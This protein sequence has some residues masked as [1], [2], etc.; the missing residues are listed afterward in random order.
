MRQSTIRRAV[1]AASVTTMAGAALVVGGAAAASADPVTGT[2]QTDANL[3]GN[4]MWYSRTVS[5]GAPIFGD[6]VTITTQLERR[7][8]TNANLVYWIEDLHPGCFDY[9]DKSATWT[10]GTTEYTHTGKPS[11]VYV[12]DASMKIDP[13]AANS[14]IPPVKLVAEY[15]VNCDAGPLLTGGL[16][17]DGTTFD[18]TSAS[19]TV[20]PTVT[21]KRMGTS[22]F[23]AQPAHPQV[24]QPV[25]FNAVTTNVPDGGQVAFTV[26]GV[27]AGT[28]T[29]TNNQASLTFTPTSAGATEVRA[30][31]VQTGTHGGSASVVRTINVSQ[32]NVEATVSVAATAGARVGHATQL[33]ATVAPAGAGGT[34]VFSDHGT[35]IGSAPVGADGT[36][37]IE[38][39]P[40]VAGER[41]I[42]ADYSGRTGVN[43]SNGAT[44]VI[45]A[46]ADPSDVASTTT[47][48]PITNGTVGEQVTLSATVD[49]GVAGGTVTFYD[50][51]TVIG[52]ANVNE[53]GQATVNWT[54][55]TDGDRTVRA[56]YSG[57]GVYLSSQATAQVFIAPAIVE[58]EPDPDPVDPTDPDTG[59]L[60]SLTGSGDTG[61]ASGSLGSLGNFGS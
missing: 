11:E 59:S 52:T 28:G 38:W 44:N 39:I 19:K 54:P 41:T 56:V 53:N 21:V 46:A 60:G 2:G 6:T 5:N 26:D 58:P 15:V 20:G 42:D 4:S 25:T 14:W 10:I 45:V 33:T 48:E 9:V 49:A 55:S 57:E 43:A 51:L 50:G 24:G 17:W 34:V 1:A 27:S 12:N 23:L 18:G 13:P 8:G 31:F 30:N 35:E 22:V 37:T 3:I 7:G 36:A 47:L 32:A 29:V 16:D 40:S 61:N